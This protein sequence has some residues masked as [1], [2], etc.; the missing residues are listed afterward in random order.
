MKKEKKRADD[1]YCLFLFWRTTSKTMLHMGAMS[2]RGQ[3]PFNESL[4]S[5]WLILYIFIPVSFSYDLINKSSK[6][7]CRL[8]EQ[9][10][11]IQSK[12]KKVVLKKKMDQ[13][14]W[15]IPY[16]PYRP[17]SSA[18]QHVIGVIR[19]EPP[20]ISVS[21]SWAHATSRRLDSDHW[22]PRVTPLMPA[23][24]AHHTTTAIFFFVPQAALLSATPASNQLHNSHSRVGIQTLIRVG[25]EWK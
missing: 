21:S 8:T 10:V 24:T 12:H 17:V 11:L 20:F 23:I 15:I 18:G 25:G 1:S 2:I 19:W 5:F 4:A 9:E 14:Q 7:K 6:Q 13:T 16:N 22:R 3:K